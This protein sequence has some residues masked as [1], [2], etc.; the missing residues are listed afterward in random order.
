MEL[1]EQLVA[2]VLAADFI[3]PAWI[4]LGVS[5]GNDFDDIAAMEFCVEPNHLAVNDGASAASADFA[6]ES[7][8]EIKWH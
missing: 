3:E 1:R 8:S 5:G 7:I 6:M 4:W 2:G